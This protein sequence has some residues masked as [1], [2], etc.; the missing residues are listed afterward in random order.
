[1]SVLEAVT[2]ANLLIVNKL[3]T[4]MNDWSVDE[5]EAW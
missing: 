3:S 4:D 1:M 5:K 2:M